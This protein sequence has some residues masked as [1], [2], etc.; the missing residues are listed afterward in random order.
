MSHN[1]GRRHTRFR[2]SYSGFALEPR[3]SASPP[4]ASLLGFFGASLLPCLRFIGFQQ[5]GPPFDTRWGQAKNVILNILNDPHNFQ[6]HV[7]SY[8]ATTI[9]KLTAGKTTPTLETDPKIKEFCHIAKIYHPILRHRYY[10]LDSIPWLKYL[11]RYAPE[12]RDGFKRTMG[13]FTGKLNRVRHQTQSNEGIGP[14]FPKYIL[15]NGH[16][17]GLTE[18][19]MAYLAGVLFGA[20][21]QT[22]RHLPFPRSI[23]ALTTGVKFEVATLCPIMKISMAD[24]SYVSVKP[25]LTGNISKGIVLCGKGHIPDTRAAFDAA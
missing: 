20:R 21:S 15:E 9:L 3:S 19:K 16:L 23:A 24:S 5:T 1:L 13:L 6:H 14:S 8:A 7:S 17:R 11:P 2:F 25:S 10:L 18:S 22:I 12:L 4:R